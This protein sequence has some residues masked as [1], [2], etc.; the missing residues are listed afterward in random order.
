MCNVSAGV[1][2]E[3]IHKGIGI[4]VEQTKLEDLRSVLS[5]TAYTF[6]E[7]AEMINIPKSK[8]ESYTNL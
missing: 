7:V 1:Y 3:G 4:G 6:D 2:E 5:K 8:W